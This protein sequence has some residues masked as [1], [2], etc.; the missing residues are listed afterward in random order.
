VTDAP[1]SFSSRGPSLF[2]VTKPDVSAPGVNVRS[3]VPGGYDVYSGTSMASPHTAGTVAL[4][5]S[6]YPNLIRDIESTERKLR[7]AA[8]ILN[9]TD[10]CGGD[11][12]T[13]H[14][15]NSFGSGRIDAVQTQNPFPVYVDRAVY[16][17]GDT[18]TLKV[19]LVNPRNETWP[20]DPYLGIQLA[21]GRVFLWQFGTL[22]VPP[23]FEVFDVQQLSATLTPDVPP[24]LHRWFSVLVAPGA[25]PYDPATHLAVDLASFV[26]QP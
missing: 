4:L 14:P 7:P 3:S 9:S 17:T 5:W 10:P 13:S 16:S 6:E 22:D 21:D 20:V 8:I 15:N 25:D 24:G 12:P 2:G 19:S 26:I 18:M 23:L 11:S 1:A